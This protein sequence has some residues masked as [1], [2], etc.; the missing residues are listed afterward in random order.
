V[1]KSF[2]EEGRRP[3]EA[4]LDSYGSSIDANLAPH[5]HQAR[6]NMGEIYPNW[7]TPLSPVAAGTGRSG[8][9]HHARLRGMGSLEGGEASQ[10]WANGELAWEI[11]TA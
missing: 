9:P 6:G 1:L 2:I 4:L 10:F 8:V 3:L 7:Y 11:F 5:S